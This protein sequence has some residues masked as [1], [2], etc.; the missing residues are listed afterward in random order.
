MTTDFDG[1]C[2]WCGS[3]MI[4]VTDSTNPAWGNNDEAIL[5]EDW[6]CMDCKR[7]FS[8]HSRIQV[9]HRTL[10]MNVNCPYCGDTDHVQPLGEMNELEWYRCTGCKREFFVRPESFYRRALE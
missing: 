8:T 1:R 6:T 4:E 9:V 3:Y 2:P 5:D 10:V 7:C